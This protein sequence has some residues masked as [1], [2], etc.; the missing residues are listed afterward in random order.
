MAVTEH[1]P[2]LSNCTAVI[3]LE[4]NGIEAVVGPI[5]I[6]YHE[7]TDEVFMECEDRRVWLPGEHFNAIIKQLRRANRM[8]LE[9]KGESNG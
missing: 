5:S 1:H 4:H 6:G 2:G 8:A 3:S 7:G 9:A